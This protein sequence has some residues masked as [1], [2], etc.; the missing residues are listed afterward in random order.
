MNHSR[1]STLPCGFPHNKVQSPAN[2]LQSIERNSKPY[3][4]FDDRPIQVLVSDRVRGGEW[5]Q[6]RV[7]ANEYCVNVSSSFC[8]TKL[9]LDLP[10]N[11]NGLTTVEIS[12]A[13]FVWS[14]QNSQF[15][16]CTHGGGLDPSPKAWET[17]LIGSIPI[18]QHSYVAHYAVYYCMMIFILHKRIARDVSLM[19]YLYIIVF[20]GH[21]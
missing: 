11:G 8:S 6:D 18:I 14:V 1:Y 15:V 17:L 13:K 3:I 20:L 7:L 16:M 21:L 5:Y 10:G 9:D 2:L 19:I 4:P 12:H